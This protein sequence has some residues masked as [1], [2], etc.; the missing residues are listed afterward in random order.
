MRTALAAH[1]VTSTCALPESR[2]P[3]STTS[4]LWMLATLF[5]VVI[6]A[7]ETTY[8]LPSPLQSE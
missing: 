4:S 8:T 7:P 2:V 5:A 1:T 6:A 3:S